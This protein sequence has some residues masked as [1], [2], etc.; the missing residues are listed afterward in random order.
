MPMCPH[1]GNPVYRLAPSPKGNGFADRLGKAFLGELVFW[2]LLALV[3]GVGLIHW[4][5]GVM[6]GVV[7][8]GLVYYCNKSLTQYQCKGCHRV[9]SGDEVVKK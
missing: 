4:V 5:A 9:L 6:A 7:G 8:V 1:C 2:F 3:L